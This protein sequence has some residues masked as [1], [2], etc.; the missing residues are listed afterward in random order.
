MAGLESVIGY[1]QKAGLRQ[2][3]WIDGSFLTEKIDPKDV[4]IVLPIQHGQ[5]LSADQVKVINWIK[6]ENLKPIYLVDNYHFVEFPHGHR[7][8][9][10]GQ[11]ARD[12]WLDT[13]GTDRDGYKKGIA[14]VRS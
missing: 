9:D 12:Y 6:Y 3:F 4:D 11:V 2:D 7:N 14:V 13:Y 1:F 10:Q 5:K 8:F